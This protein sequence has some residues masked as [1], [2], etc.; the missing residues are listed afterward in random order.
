MSSLQA[1]AELKLLVL[2]VTTDCNLRC[3]YCYA[4]GGD[5]AR[6]M[7]WQVAR[8]ALDLMASQSSGFKIQFAG[9]EPLFNM[10]LIERVVHYTQGLSVT[11]RLQTNATLIDAATARELKRLGIDVGVS[12]DGIPAVNDPLRPFPDGH[13]STMAAISGIENL[14]SAG[15]HVGL[16]CVLSA[17]NVT[18]LCG[19]VELAS[20]LGN[21]RGIALDPLRPAGRAIEGGVGQVDPA[22][23]ARHVEAALER[24][25]ELEAMGG[26]KVIFREVERMRHLLTLR[27]RRRYRCYCDAG[28]L[29]MVRPDGDA[30]PCASLANSP[31]FCLGNVLEQ[32]F[33][34]WLVDQLQR[35]RQLIPLPHDCL[36]CPDRWVCAGQCPA[37]TYA[38]RL[39][40]EVRPV[41]CSIKRAFIDYVRRRARETPQKGSSHV[42]LPR[43]EFPGE[44]IRSGLYRELQG[45]DHRRFG[46]SL[47]GYGVGAKDLHWAIHERSALR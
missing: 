28:K 32:G 6:Y 11:Y 40:G 33:G 8:K 20:Y 7:S 19:L 9:G 21:V 26:R 22:L 41:E 34:Y 16:T 23:A 36:I 38:Q 10:E 44:R 31:D 37:Q 29:L 46:I 4:E 30:Y 39:T 24:A 42:M 5:Q 14:R 3:R 18:G 13:G 47:P 27:L 43:E 45:Q 17:E 2:W 15:I 1:P 25:D 12:L 35:C